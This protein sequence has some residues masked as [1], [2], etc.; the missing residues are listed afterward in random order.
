[1]PSRTC[2]KATYFFVTGLVVGGLLIAGIM[3]W[4]HVDTSV[5]NSELPGSTLVSIALFV[6]FIAFISYH[7]ANRHALRRCTGDD[8]CGGCIV[9]D[10]SD[11]SPYSV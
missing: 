5:E 10:E 1:M 11:D 2:I 8:D 9:D 3:K 7:P 6:L 4:A